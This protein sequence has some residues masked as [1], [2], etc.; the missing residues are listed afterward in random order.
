MIKLSKILLKFENKFC[1]SKGSGDEL[2]KFSNQDY[3]E[4]LG[5]KILEYLDFITGLW[6]DNKS[7]MGNWFSILVWY[8]K[9]RHIR[10]MNV[11]SD[12]VWIF[13]RGK[14]DFGK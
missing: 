7:S 3:F 13:Q 5:R 1:K 8:L 6:K 14:W 10:V 4:F 9:A 2:N 11:Y 12:K